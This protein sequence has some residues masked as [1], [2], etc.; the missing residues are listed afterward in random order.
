M[1]S[2]KKSE[3]KFF[4]IVKSSASIYESSGSQPF[5]TTTEIQSGPDDFEESGWVMSLTYIGVIAILSSIGRVIPEGKAG[6]EIPA[7]ARLEFL[8]KISMKHYSFVFAEGN[9]SVPFDR[10]GIAGLP[11]MGTL[12]VIRQNLQESSFW[13]AKYFCFISIIKYGSFNNPF[14]TI[15]PVRTSL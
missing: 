2:S 4:Q 13:K 3:T 5:R 6:K 14:Q 7:S 15:L 8:K 10:R 12:L 1:R 11:L 9:T